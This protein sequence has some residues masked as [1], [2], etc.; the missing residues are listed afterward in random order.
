MN[1][2]Q[3]YETIDECL[4]WIKFSEIESYKLKKK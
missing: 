4:F 3:N 1:L 2:Y